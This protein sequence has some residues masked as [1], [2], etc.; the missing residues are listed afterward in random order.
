LPA[1]ALP[2]DPSLEQLKKQA[3]DLRDLVRARIPGPLELVGAHHPEGAHAVTLTG[4]Q[5]VVARHYGFA[6]WPRLKSY[7]E[8][9][10]RYR[11]DPDGVEPAGDMANDFLVLACLR[12]RRRRQ[13]GP[14][15]TSSSAVTFGPQ[16]VA[17]YGVVDEIARRVWLNSGRV[18]AVRGDDV[19]GD[20]GAAAILRYAV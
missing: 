8:T 10:E 1:A 3:R 19:P 11:R 9:I 15:G 12:V 5:L 17:S 4:A 20:H 13:S 2:D 14:L 6:S 7:L 16:G 18:L